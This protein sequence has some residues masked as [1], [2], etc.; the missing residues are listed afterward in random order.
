VFHGGVRAAAAAIAAAVLLA[1]CGGGGR[2]EKQAPAMAPPA[3]GTPSV[4]TP[5]TS[6]QAPAAGHRR[7][8]QSTPGKSE[9]LEPTAAYRCNGRPLR[10]LSAAGPVK[11]SPAIVSPGDSFTVTVTDPSVKTADVSL[12]G[13][14][15]KPILAQGREQGGR[16]IA[17]LKMPG[18]ASCGNKLLEVEGDVSAEAYVGVRR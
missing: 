1:A 18:Y 16:L 14:A 13:V 7:K 8:G 17:T 3:T 2:K 10:A 9:P 5:A 15:P 6:G 4:T 11:V 12:T